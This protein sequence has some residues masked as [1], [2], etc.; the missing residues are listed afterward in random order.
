[1]TGT[2]LS[3]GHGYSAR[4][5]AKL[6]QPLGWQISGTTRSADKIAALKATGV[7]PLIVPGDPLELS[8]VTHLL[9][10]ASPDADGDPFLPLI[11]EA[12]A[13]HT[14]PWIGYLSTTGVYGDHQ[15]R[16]VDEKTPCTPGNQRGKWRVRAE[17]QWL[18]HDAH[19]FRLAGIYG[20]GRG[21]FSKVRNGTARRIIKPGQ[22]FGRIHVEDI[23]QVVVASIDRPNPGRIYNVCDD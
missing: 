11:K 16:W 5:V 8:G 9:I 18:E 20:P 21:P 13:T 3:L 17:Q 6:L 2:L 4:A 15:G 22:V 14:P 23:A 1:M 7:T 10:S 12:L 19:I